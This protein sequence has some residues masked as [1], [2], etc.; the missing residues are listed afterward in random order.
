MHYHSRC[1]VPQSWADLSNK[2]IQQS[3]TERNTS[4]RLRAEVDALIAATHQDMWTAWSN[5]N[6][7]LTHRA[8]DTNDTRNKLLAHRNRVS[9]NVTNTVII[10]N[11]GL[12]H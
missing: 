8:G 7:A 1:S 6:T 3:Q 9:K 12:K 4:Q 11:F 2:N 5:S 10:K